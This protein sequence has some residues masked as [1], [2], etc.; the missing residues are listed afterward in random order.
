MTRA[1]SL[2]QL[3]LA[4]RT[5]QIVGQL[6]LVSGD[7]VFIMPPGGVMPVAVLQSALRT[8]DQ[9]RG[10]SR[11]RSALRQGFAAGVLWALMGYSDAANGSRAFAWGGAGL[12][13][14]MIVG[15]VR[16]YEQWERVRR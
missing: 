3:P 14:G 8:A 5:T 6:V 13:L 12:G 11:V 7:T 1:D 4:P 15:A 2:R 16:P 9:S 10:Y